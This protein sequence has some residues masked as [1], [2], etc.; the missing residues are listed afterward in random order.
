MASVTVISGVGGKLPAAFLLEMEGYRVLLDLG[1]GPQPG[2]RPDINAIGRV[3][4]LAIAA[5]QGAVIAVPEHGHTRGLFAGH[6]AGALAAVERAPHP[7][8]SVMVDW[9][10]RRTACYPGICR[11]Q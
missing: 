11:R 10:N 3:D 7:G 1:A 9:Q 8:R 6:P 4:V 2:V 5:G